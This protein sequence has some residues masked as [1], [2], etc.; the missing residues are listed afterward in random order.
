MILFAGIPSETPI[1]LAIEAA[2]QARV[3]HVVLNQR[4][5]HLSEL[6]LDIGPDGVSGL[7]ALPEGTFRL[8]EVSGVYARIMDVDTLPEFRRGRHGL[9][10]LLAYERAAAFQSSFL[11]WLELASCRVVS[12]PSAMFSNNSKPYQGRILEGCGFA[13]PRTLVTN[14]PGEVR[15]FARQHGRLVYKSTSG[16]RSIVQVLDARG[17]ERLRRIRMLPTQFQPYIHGVDVRVHVVGEDVYATEVSSGAVDYRYAN[18]SGSSVTV[19]PHDLPDAIVDRCLAA[20]QRLDLPLCGLDL[21]RSPSGEYVCFEANPMPAY[22]YYQLAAR[23]PIATSLVRYLAEEM[24]AAN[25]SG[26]RELVGDPGS[27][28]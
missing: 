26:H 5:M 12:R 27:S 23:Q 19:Q 17:V 10:T 16:A 25:G 20:S 13:I 14:D 6:T 21:R 1:C 28:S 18:R 15:D 2:E 11:D 9:S 22:S 24:Q 4:Q 8:D 3:P 7:I